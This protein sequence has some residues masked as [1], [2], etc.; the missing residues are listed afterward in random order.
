MYAKRFN[1]I[2]KMIQSQ[3]GDVLYIN[4][5]L[6]S[7]DGEQH[8]VSKFFDKKSFFFNQ[9]KYVKYLENKKSKDH[10]L[11]YT[12]ALL[13]ERKNN[14]YLAHIAILNSD[15]KNK[16]HKA[17]MSFFQ[18]KNNLITNNNYLP[19]SVITYPI[20]IVNKRGEKIYILIFNV[21][22]QS[23]V[24][25]SA[26]LEL[27]Q[28]K[29]HLILKDFAD[30]YYSDIIHKIQLKTAV[31]SIL[32]DSYAHNISAHSLAALKWWM[33]LRNKMLDKRFEV[34]PTGL[35]L[36]CIQ[37][38]LYNVDNTMLSETSERYYEALGK[39]DSI[40][41][42]N[43]YSLYD[44]INFVE[45]EYFNNFLQIQSK[46]SDKDDNEFHPRFPVPIDYAL[47]PFFKFLRDKGAFW[48]GVT[49][50]TS[51]GGE[52]KTWFKILWE[53][54]ANNPLYL[55]TIAKTE[56][57]NKI[58][59]YLRVNI[60][61]EEIEGKFITIDLSII[62]YESKM[63]ES[64]DLDESTDLHT[65][66]V[67]FDLSN[68]QIVTDAA[69][70]AYIN[71]LKET[72]KTHNDQ[73]TNYTPPKKEKIIPF[74]EKNKYSKYSF[75]KLGERFAQFR[76]VLDKGTNPNVFLPA[77]I[78]GEHALFTIL[79]NTIRNIKHINDEEELKKIREQGIDFWISIEE[80][81]ISTEE[82][83]NNLKKPELFRVGIWLQHPTP[84]IRIVKK[85]KK[86]EPQI[87][88]FDITEQ[89]TKPVLDED[90][91]S[92]RMGGNSQDKVCAAMLFNNSFSAVEIKRSNSERGKNYFPWI[93][94]STV[95]LSHEHEYILKINFD[96]K[97][98][99][100]R[101]KIFYLL[102]QLSYSL[103]VS[104]YNSI[105]DSLH[106]QINKNSQLSLNSKDIEKELEKYINSCKNDGLLRNLIKTI[107][108]QY[109]DLEFKTNGYL[110]KY[111]NLWQSNS[112]LRIKNNNDLKS[113]NISRF[114]F[115]AI[116]NDSLFNF[117][118]QEGVIRIVKPKNNK[119]EDK[120]LY[121]LWLKE[122][123]NLEYSK[124]YYIRFKKGDSTLGLLCISGDSISY[125]GILLSE[126][127][128]IKGNEIGEIYFVHSGASQEK[129]ECNV[130]SHG[131]FWQIFF[132]DIS[133]KDI[134]YLRYEVSD[135][136]KAYKYPSERSNFLWEFVEC[137]QTRITIFDNRVFIRIPNEKKDPDEEKDMFKKY[138]KLFVFEEDTHKW[139][140]FK[141]LDIQG[142]HV[143][144]MHLT[145]IEKIEKS[146]IRYT[147][148]TI[149]EFIDNELGSF[150][151]NKNF[152]FIITTG[153]GRDR[154]REILNEK[155]KSFTI[156]KPIE[157]ILSAVE[158]GV[159]N[160]DH[161]D[162]KYNLVKLIFGS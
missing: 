123:L 92:P 75:I 135:D 86:I 152:I 40:Y 56:G 30:V 159:Y 150:S 72:I 139:D 36:S 134:K 99:V 125:N 146:G 2:F 44:L 109:N 79:E 103:D 100:L 132:N 124:E 88:I 4:A 81:N 5:L 133:I 155:Q 68:S 25:I 32:V 27:N 105:I 141:K 129:H 102:S 85:E 22:V 84:L 54:F 34:P 41:N 117:A 19:V 80:K 82:N 136:N 17:I 61:A 18:N 70:Q 158:E 21:L 113:E 1:K 3:I 122:W 46:V 10:F 52:T 90:S 74:V 63:S 23:N 108:S 93:T 77:G 49:R 138:L 59:I 104:S 76:E 73:C 110:K 64:T 140:D 55:G 161:F 107:A 57:V 11:T 137:L 120:D 13:K 115:I 53:D 14:N 143:L 38:C 9:E 98:E 96:K 119:L 62:D 29:I 45:P 50:D 33:D 7:D 26:M 15:Y 116:D 66:I 106:N 145:F 101:S 148:E 121:Y 43:F 20:C 111:I 78:V 47:V 127:S 97:K 83:N 151:K 130:R 95:N 39:T 91:G 37:P 112:Y 154:W 58:N 118:R 6:L 126:N 156:F 65:K 48:S 94:F 35:T 12:D 71:N 60:G 153:R 42:R 89:T 114:K 24:A 8:Y 162:I 28:Y 67:K 51:F 144:I 157:S 131:K 147:E 87:L 16:L 142:P 69:D 149:N 160:N 31:I 128:T